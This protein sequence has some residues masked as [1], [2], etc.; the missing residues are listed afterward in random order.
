MSFVVANDAE[1]LGHPGA[2]GG[3]T[4]TYEILINAGN[5]SILDNGGNGDLVQA[6]ASSY[7]TFSFARFENNL[8]FQGTSGANSVHLTI[9][10]H[11]AGGSSP[12]VIESIQ[13][14]SLGTSAYNL[15][16]TL[17]GGSGNDVVAGSSS[18]DNL[19][20]GAGKDLLFGSAGNDTLNGGAGNDLLAGGTGSDTF[21]FGAP[22]GAGNVDTITDFNAIE[23]KILLVNVVP[24]LFDAIPE[25]SG[26]LAAEAFDVV[27]AGAAATNQT[28]ITYDPTTGALSYDA[29]GT[30]ATAAVQV[31]TLSPN[32]QLDHT[33]FTYD[34]AP[35]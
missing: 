6:A 20:G 4:Q 11:Y 16:T 32:L 22:L 15:S 21:I 19:S 9:L 29:D 24:G 25:G 26:T 2:G 1:D 30:G 18:N 10:D 27:G 23:D 14:Y 28:R 5:I 17:A 12:N 34:A 31:A 13:G 3:S 33:N 35:L 8:E 7:E